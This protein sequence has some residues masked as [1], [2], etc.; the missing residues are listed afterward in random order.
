LVPLLDNKVLTQEQLV[1]LVEQ[2][3]RAYEANPE[4]EGNF[5]HFLLFHPR[6]GGMPAMGLDPDTVHGVSGGPVYDH[7]TH[8]VAGVFVGGMPDE[9]TMAAASWAFH[10][11]ALPVQD[12]LA[13]LKED[14][15]LE[16]PA[17]EALLAKLDL[18]PAED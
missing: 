3:A 7:H 11:I 17:R 15:T 16:Q 4:P 1:A 10:E 5:D 2:L 9:V 13:R 12:I 18:F 14:P 8:C 6:Y